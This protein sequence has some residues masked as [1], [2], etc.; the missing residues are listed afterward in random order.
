MSI[1]NFTPKLYISIGSNSNYYTLRETY[2]HVTK[3]R[4]EVRCFHHKNLSINLD[5]AIAKAEE[6]SLNSGIPFSYNRDLINQQMSEIVRSTPDEIQRRIERAERLEKEA[7]EAREKRDAAELARIKEILKNGIMPIGRHNGQT[8]K[9]LPVGYLE[10]LESSDFTG[11]IIMETIAKTV[12][13]TEL[14]R[15]PKFNDEYFGEVGK[16]VELEVRVV[17]SIGIDTFYG[18]SYITTMID[19]L[20]HCITV[21]SGSFMPSEDTKLKIKATIKDHK[22]YKGQ[23]QTI[24]Q[25]VK[26]LEEV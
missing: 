14:H 1:A 12:L 15:I 26:V 10:W 18:R 16:R 3:T 7:Q 20:N 9:S 6:F 17:K 23:K 4:A 24:V 2:L 25:R 8:F 19:N 21:F 11:N 22:D 5:E 13:A